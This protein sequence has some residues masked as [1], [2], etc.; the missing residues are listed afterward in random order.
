[1]VARLQQGYEIR[2]PLTGQL[3]FTVTAYIAS[4]AMG[5]V[6]VVTSAG[7]HVKRAMKR[8]SEINH[9]WK[10][11]SITRTMMSSSSAAAAAA[12]SPF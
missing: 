3:L 2:L 6:Y 4:G 12:N 5:E 11:F 7:S 1:M 8:V 10:K 9:A